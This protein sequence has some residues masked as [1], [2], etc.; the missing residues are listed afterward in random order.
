MREVSDFE[1]SKYNLTSAH[2]AY[3][4]PCFEIMIIPSVLCDLWLT[5]FFVFS[6]NCLGM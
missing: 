2:R 1:V 6:E 4:H 5:A 3:I